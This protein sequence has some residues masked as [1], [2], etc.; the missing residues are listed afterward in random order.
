MLVRIQKRHF[1][2]NE[3]YRTAEAIFSEDDRVEL[4][5]GEII[6]MNAVG[7]RH[8]TC[9]KRIV[10]A[11]ANQN[12]RRVAVVS[13]RD[14]IQLD[15]YSE[16]QPDVALLRPRP[17]FYAQ[18]HP[19]AS[20]VLPVVEVAHTSVGYD[21]QVKLPLYARSG[22]PEVWLVNLPAD[23]IEV[24][25]RLVGGKYQVVKRAGRGEFVLPAGVPN[26]ALSVD[27]ILG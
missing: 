17:D 19:L 25:A 14:P 24:Y 6:E 11:L 7:S 13:V 8:A 16:P 18:A 12:V 26:L 27:A 20:D 23:V 21:A 3:Y 10:D 5:E 9:V 1:N 15:D 22:I 2:V 4:I